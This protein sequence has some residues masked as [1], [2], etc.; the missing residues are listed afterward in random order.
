V[1]IAILG[2]FTKFQYKLKSFFI[3][4]TLCFTCTITFSQTHT[5]DSIQ[6]TLKNLSEDTTKVKAYFK[7]AEEYQPIDNEKVIEFA[8]KGLSLAK[9]I[10]WRKGIGIAFAYLGEAYYSLGN[11]PLALANQQQELRIWEEL[12][13][14]IKICI[15]KSN[16]GGTYAD[17]GNFLKAVEYYFESLALAEKLGNVETVINANSNIGSLYTEMGDD[18]KAILYYNKALNLA[19]KSKHYKQIGLVYGNLGNIYLNPE[20]VQLA[21][22]YYRKAIV[23]DEQNGITSHMSAWLSGIGNCHRILADSLRAVGNLKQHDIE[24][25]KGEE[26]LR[27][28]LIAATAVKNKFLEVNILGNLSGLLTERNQFAE[29]EKALIRSREISDSIGVYDGLQSYYFRSYELHKR[30]NNLSKALYFF[31]KYQTIED[32]LSNVTNKKAVR[33]LEMKYENVRKESDIKLLTREKDI[34]LL[35]MKNDQ[36]LTIAIISI[37]VLIVGLGFIY[38]HKIRLKSKKENE[39]LSQ[40]LLRTQMNPH[41]IFN[42]LS[43][44]ESFIYENKPK[45]AG[46]YLARFAKLMRLT[47]ECSDEESITLS[48]ELEML[49]YYLDLQ[50]LR[51]NDNMSFEIIVD[52]KIQPERIKLPPMLIQ[53][54]IENTIEHAFRGMN[55]EGKIKIMFDIT[56]KLLQIKIIDNGIGIESSMRQKE[57]FQTHKS[58]AIHITKQRLA[59]IRKPG[60]QVASLSIKDIAC[61]GL[62]GTEVLFSIPI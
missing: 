26:Y 5:I 62:K 53:P 44:I 2:F 43:S 24:L 6:I 39:L 56:G 57:N 49:R 59:L 58:R 32:S 60:E 11:Y 27:K 42:S 7:I 61:N 40:K 9:K 23:A 21:Q 55:E 16:I 38:I 52:K 13:N 29:A 46:D 25:L 31:E 17:L 35:K 30:S 50:K 3:I 18:E 54:F 14:E 12:H 51:L 45:I 22:Y 36:Y 28:A 4:F 19:I 41:F 20:K 47:L 34:L 33:E 8:N 1:K 10:N 15:L 37:S 48:S